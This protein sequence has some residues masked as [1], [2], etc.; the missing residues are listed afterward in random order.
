MARAKSGRWDLN[1]IKGAREF[2]HSRD[3]RKSPSKPHAHLSCECLMQIGL[4]L[5][6][7]LLV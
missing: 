2:A 7:A 6:A 5:V 1:H 4:A 3:N